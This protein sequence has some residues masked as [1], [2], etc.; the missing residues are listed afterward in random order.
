MCHAYNYRHIKQTKQADK[1]HVLPLLEKVMWEI[2]AG[3]KNM[4]GISMRQEL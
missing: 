1:A 3:R 4:I 2:K